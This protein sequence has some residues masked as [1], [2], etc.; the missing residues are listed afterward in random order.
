[1]YWCLFSLWPVLYL[2]LN[3]FN[4]QENKVIDKLKDFKHC[5]S[6]TSSNTIKVYRNIISATHSLICGLGCLIAYITGSLFV[7]DFTVIYS[8]SYFIW[9]SYYIVVGGGLDDYPFLFHHA[10]T[11]Y[12]LKLIIDGY[13]RDYLLLF[14]IIGEFSN[15]PYYVVYHKLKTFCKNKN[16]V[17]IWRHIQISWFVLLRII[18]LGYYAFVFPYVVDNYLLLGLC[19]MMYFLGIY[20]SFGQLK[21]IYRDYYI[22]NE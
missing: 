22:K 1:M 9:D 20:W 14:V 13:L 3:K 7:L 4:K 18:I 17:R 16:N 11:I 5:Y 19:F 21:G 12:V 10:V 8:I 6:I 2:L 15:L